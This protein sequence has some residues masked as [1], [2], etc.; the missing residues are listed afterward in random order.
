MGKYEK[1][2]ESDIHTS[3]AYV[4]L[5]VS[6][7]I[8]STRSASTALSTLARIRLQGTSAEFPTGVND[9]HPSSK[10]FMMEHESLSLPSTDGIVFP[11]TP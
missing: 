8:A 9:I 4:L 11:T 3:A 1:T 2:L 10:K 5:F 7:N 6:P